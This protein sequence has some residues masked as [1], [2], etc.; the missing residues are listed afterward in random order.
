M[1]ALTLF[2]F[3]Y[4]LMYGVTQ[5]C[6][7]HTLTSAGTVRL[8]VCVTNH[9]V[10]VDVNLWTDRRSHHA[11]LHAAVPRHLDVRVPF[12]LVFQNLVLFSEGEHL[13]GEAFDVR[14]D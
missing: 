3:F 7:L 8:A 10:T 1:V 4:P 6:R 9:C 11:G 12:Y 13:H 14:R 5:V 2:Y